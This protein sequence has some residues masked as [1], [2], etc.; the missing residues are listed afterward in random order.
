MMSKRA[1]K[2]YKKLRQQSP[3]TLPSNMATIETLS[4]TLGT[5]SVFKE[6]EKV[7]KVH[8]TPKGTRGGRCNVTACQRENSAIFLNLGMTYGSNGQSHGCWYCIDCAKDIHEA[9]LQYR[10]RDGFTLFPAFDQMISRYKELWKARKNVNDPELYADINQNPWGSCSHS[11]RDAFLEA[12][13]NGQA[14]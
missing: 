3:R 2:N 1:I 13:A 12:Q 4:T 7:E 11:A 8:T 5:A 6:P 10:E 9:N 14:A